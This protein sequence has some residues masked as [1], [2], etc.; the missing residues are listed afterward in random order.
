M[1]DELKSG[2]GGVGAAKF[3]AKIGIL[4][5][6]AEV[7]M[8]IEFPLPFVAPTFYKLDLSETVILIGGFSMGPTAALIIELLK[9]L[10]NLLIN[11]TATFG[12]GELGNFLIG[13]SFTIPA[14]VIYRFKK[15]R[16]GALVSLLTG[17]ISLAVVG[18]AI[19]YFLL[20][21]AYAQAFIHDDI[22]IGA[23]IDMI[24]SMGGVIFPWVKNL[25]MFVLSCVMPFNLIKGIICSLLCYIL[26][27]R[28]SPVPHI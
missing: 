13:C 8:L 25:F 27:K 14:A 19:N 11:G 22:G 3:A 17:T 2:K 1:K 10:L 7:L 12:I 6:I 4:T 20:V 18:A 28:V 9:N 5:A 21:P 15:S 23:K 26:Y 24:V 16:G